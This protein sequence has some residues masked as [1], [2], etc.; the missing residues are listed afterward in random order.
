MLQVSLLKLNKNCEN[1]VDKNQQQLAGIVCLICWHLV[2]TISE[3]LQPSIQHGRQHKKP[4]N[5]KRQSPQRIATHP[6]FFLTICPVLVPQNWQLVPLLFPP[7]I[8]MMV[9]PC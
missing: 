3:S 4:V 1:E 8:L 2:H 5:H 6:T 7:S 9:G